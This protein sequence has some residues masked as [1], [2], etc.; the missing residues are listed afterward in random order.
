MDSFQRWYCIER[1]LWFPP[2]V[3]S[4]FMA[5]NTKK[6]NESNDLD[7]LEVPWLQ[8]HPYLPSAHSPIFDPFRSILAAETTPWIR[9]AAG[10]PKACSTRGTLGATRRKLQ[11]KQRSA[12]RLRRPLKILKR[13]PWWIGDF[14]GTYRITLGGVL[15]ILRIFFCKHW[16]NRNCWRRTIWWQSKPSG[17]QCNAEKLWTF[18]AD[19]SIHNYSVAVS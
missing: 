3:E 9:A 1:N 15:K 4:C 14:V 13:S 6:S 10:A 7:D 8:K 17:D 19:W 11:W 2:H 18:L 12:W 5:F 16:R